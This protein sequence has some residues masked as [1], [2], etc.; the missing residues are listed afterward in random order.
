M[1]YKERMRRPK[2][3]IYGGEN[4]HA[5]IYKD[6]WFWRFVLAFAID[7]GEDEKTRIFTTGRYS[8][9]GD[10][11]RGMLSCM[12]AVMGTAFADEARLYVSGSA[13]FPADYWRGVDG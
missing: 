12:A 6:G 13:A 10:A 4:W 8:S 5:E 1:G 2:L 7:S 11:R 3:E 9:A